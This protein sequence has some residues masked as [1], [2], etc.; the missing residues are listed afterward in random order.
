MYFHSAEVMAETRL[1]ERPACGIERLSGG[2]QY[3][4]DYRGHAE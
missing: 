1:E 2:P 4:V 3:V